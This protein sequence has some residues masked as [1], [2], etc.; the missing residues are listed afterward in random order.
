MSF[1]ARPTLERR[2]AAALRGSVAVLLLGPRQC[3]KTTLARALARRRRA[4]YFD[5]EDPESGLAPETAALTLRGLRGLVVIDECQRQPGLFPLLRVLADRRPAPARFLLL[6]SA[7]PEMAR[8]SSES[9]A[10]RVRHVD[11]GGL[12]LEETGGDGERLWLRGGFPRSYLASSERESLQWRSDFIRT[13]LE[14]DLPQLGVRV[15]APALR[16]FWAMLAHL[17]AQRWNS[18]DLAR[19]M[20]TQE[21]TA[22]RYLDILTGSFMLRQL[23]PWF[24]NTG[25]RLV[26]SPKVY[27]RDTGLLHA[28]LGVRSAADLR[29]H[30]RLGFSW[31][32][33]ALEQVI[34]SAQADHESYFYATHSGA[35]LDLL[36]VRGGKRQGF[37]FKY[38]DAPKATRS[39]HEVIKDLRLTRL[40]VVYPGSRDYPLGERIH[41]VPL[42]SLGKIIR[43][44]TG[45]IA[46]AWPRR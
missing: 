27:F 46:A 14:R 31:E 19:S 9:L 38:A 44:D 3:G 13:H 28:L 16:R 37:E 32:G 26:K 22:R 24:E 7:S 34:R 39:M 4:A 8:N 10:G 25:K 6:G 15:P 2:L 23:Q 30:P 35:E 45:E 40:W 11:M 42:A 29:R 12:S 17:H 43:S 1:L 20:R 21:D 36:I 41:A 5:L 18:A 33:F